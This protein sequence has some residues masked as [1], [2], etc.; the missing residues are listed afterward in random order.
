MRMEFEGSAIP[1]HLITLDDLG[2]DHART[3]GET[4]VRVHLSDAD[5]LWLGDHLWR[6]YTEKYL[7]EDP[8]FVEEEGTSIPVPATLFM[9]NP[10]RLR[11]F[12]HPRSFWYHDTILAI[13]KLKDT[14]EA[15]SPDYQF[16]IQDFRELHDEDD[17]VTLV[18][19]MTPRTG[20]VD[21]WP[22]Y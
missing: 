11:E 6:L 10:A 13:M 19:G 15:R 9:E 12:L 3:R 8:E 7:P 2:W 21:T 4:E 17:G 22:V 14:Y 18:L 1:M 5:L 16:M 20:K